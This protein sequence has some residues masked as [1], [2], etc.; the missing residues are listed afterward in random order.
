MLLENKDVFV[1]A[2]IG[3]NH[4]G[5]TD[6]AKQI[7][8]IAY[9]CGANCVKFQKRDIDL[10]YTKEFLDLPRES[11]FGTTQRH[12]K[13]GIELTEDE[14]KEIDIY[15]KTKGIDWFASS[16]DVNS[17]EFLRKFDLKYNKVASAMIN[18]SIVDMILE[19]QKFTFISTGMATFKEIDEIVEKFNKVGCPFA[20]LHCVSV[21][22]CPD[23][24]CNLS[25]IPLLKQ[26]YPGVSI[27]YSSHALGIL[28]QPIAVALGAEVVESH[29]TN[30]RSAYGSD[31]PSSLEKDAF[32]RVVRDCR[33]V[34]TLLGKG[35]E[36][37]ISP[38][39]E[40]IAKKL[41]V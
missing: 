9:E 37:L 2:E 21:Y 38:E 33:N 15:C 5:S 12:Q 24:L 26:R 19:E 7:I 31:N 17:Q 6:T 4:S 27:G 35:Y 41:K 10:V 23:E 34:K 1:I 20:L 18:H 40:A 14:Y 39:E 3:I 13:E 11:P 25:I 22:P 32:R 36:K 28:T 29:I 30:S 8:D 16:W